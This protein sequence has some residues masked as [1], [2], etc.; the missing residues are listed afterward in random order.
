M[1]C[2]ICQKKMQYIGHYVTGQ[3]RD[4]VKIYRCSHCQNRIEVKQ[5]SMFPPNHP[6]QLPL[7][8]ATLK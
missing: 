1:K 7:F 2:D 4:D 3:N 5:L 8:E 6:T